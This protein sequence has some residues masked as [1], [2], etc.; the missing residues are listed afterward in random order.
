MPDTAP[1]RGTLLTLLEQ[2]L[3]GGMN[4]EVVE[5][6]QW[7]LHYNTYG[8]VSATCRQFGIARTTFYRWLKRFDPTDLSTL[9]DKPTVSH[10]LCHN[11]HSAQSQK[12]DSFLYHLKGMLR[13]LLKRPRIVTLLLL[14]FLNISFLL[15][16]APTLADAASSWNPTLLVNT[17]AFQVIDD[18]DT[19]SDVYIQFGDTLQKKLTYE[20]TSERFNFNDD[21]NV[22][23]TAS[24]THLHAEEMLSGS[25]SVKVQ[26]RID[27]TTSVQVLD[28]DGGNP[29]L[30]IDTTNEHVG[31]GT[32]NPS[33]QLEVYNATGYTRILAHSDG[34][35]AWITADSANNQYAGINLKEAGTQ[36]WNIINAGNDN[37]KLIISAGGT[38]NQK[39]IL[40]PTGELGIDTATPGS[41]LSVSGSVIIGEAL[42]SSAAD[43]GLSLEIL[44]TASGRILHGQDRLTSSGTLSIEGAAMFGSTVEL[45]SVTYTFPYSDGTASGKVLKT[46]G[47]GQLSWATDSNDGGITQGTA[48]DRYVRVAG[49]TMTGALLITQGG[50]DSWTAETTLEVKG[51]MS[52]QRLNISTTEAVSTGAL[53]LNNDGVGTGMLLD[54]ESS[55]HAGL[56]IDMPEVLY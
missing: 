33:E 3:D 32:A 5:R 7:F 13:T 44:G 26:N 34:S 43:D 21:V 31:I 29:V 1:T 19:A 51:T 52:G 6:L 16:V 11:A 46:D 30:N 12:D 15:L 24:G 27:S 9:T 54:S 18:D 41:Q 55:Q 8:S 48:D 40:Q 47:N 49:D 42:G 14:L 28:A 45:N 2:A 23:G 4:K 53:F 56:A 25:G 38:E 10:P 20:R 36:K 22:Q 39:V 17:E 50:E 35:A 37:D